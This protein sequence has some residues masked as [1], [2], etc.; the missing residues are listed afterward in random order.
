M[1]EPGRL[2]ADFRF[3]VTTSALRIEG[4]DDVDGRLP[5]IWDAVSAVPGRT[6]DGST[7]RVAVDHFHRYPDDVA[8]LAELGVDAYRFS[9][10]WSR[11]QPTG[12]GDANQRGLDFYDRLVDE[13]L[14]AG[15]E[16]WV[17]VYHWDLPLETMLAGGWLSRDTAGALG[18]LAAL[19]ADRI[20]DRV[21]RWT[22]IADPLVHMAYGHALGV[23]APGLTLLADAF[24][25]AH[26]LL[27]GH[28]RVREVLSANSS[29][30][31]GIANHH[32]LVTPA[33][34]SA[35]DRV[36]AAHYDAYHNR[37]FADP[38][39]LG[40]Y[41]RLLRPLLE[42]RPGVVRDGDLDAIAGPLDFYGVSYFHPTTVAAAPDNATIPFAVVESPDAD[43]TDSQWP[44][45]PESLTAVLVDLHRRYP[46]LPPLV[47]TENG[48][49]YRDVAGDDGQR[50]SAGFL[51]DR[52]RIEYIR[53]HLSAVADAV[54]AGVD[55]RGYFHRGLTDGWEGAD[56]FSQQFGLVRVDPDS[57]DRSTRASFD[58]FRTVIGR[59]RSAHT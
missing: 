10:S 55:V 3:G 48:A 18:D 4:A 13:L 16:P 6:V 42:R 45:A 43:V 20:G 52:A 56:G 12:H 41:P 7:G 38:I 46:R 11:V 40:R 33:G 44:V 29:A 53:S 39:L 49:S 37:Q 17:T 26:H 25:A 54:A 27:L 31:V 35:A 1:P 32:T 28:A 59:H 14:G 57:L 15:I 34:V 8:L 58:F 2:P 23:D 21:R 36:A 19:V 24:T 51:P 47:I 22:T 50:D 9:I 5:S 30:I